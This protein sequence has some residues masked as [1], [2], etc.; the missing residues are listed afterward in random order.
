MNSNSRDRNRNLINF[1]KTKKL[2]REQRAN[3]TRISSKKAESDRSQPQTFCGDAPLSMPQ[4]QKTI[5]PNQIQLANTREPKH[6]ACNAPPLPR[7][8]SKS[9]PLSSSQIPAPP[10]SVTSRYKT[11]SQTRFTTDTRGEK[12][13]FPG[14]NASTTDFYTSALPCLPRSIFGN[15]SIHGSPWNRRIEREEG[16]RR[17]PSTRIKRGEIYF[18]KRGRKHFIPADGKLD[19]RA[20]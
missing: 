12:N 2:T 4:N 7:D 16:R 6:R 17:R 14:K 1:P 5:P 15:K 13:I 11:V 10:G 20:K 18:Y 3:E 19:D 8:F 9:L